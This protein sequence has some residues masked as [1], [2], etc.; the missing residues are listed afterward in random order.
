MKRHHWQKKREP[1]VF[2]HAFPDGDRTRRAK[3]QDLRRKAERAAVGRG[4]LPTVPAEDD[5]G[6][7]AA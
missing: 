7:V 5:A 1:K 3:A 2:F 4:V 6:E